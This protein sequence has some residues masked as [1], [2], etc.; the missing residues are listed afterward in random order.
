[1]SAATRGSDQK[2]LRVSTSSFYAT[3]YRSV[4]EGITRLLRF[5]K[6]GP[7]EGPEPSLLQAALS[8]VFDEA[9]GASSPLGEWNI[10]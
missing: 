8:T 6:L 3:V 2:Q 1:M 9:Q 7:K 10:A 5:S 4:H